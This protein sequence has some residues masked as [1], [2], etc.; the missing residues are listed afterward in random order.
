MNLWNFFKVHHSNKCTGMRKN[1]GYH[2]QH[3]MEVKLKA[4]DQC[5]LR[6]CFGSL[7]LPLRLALYG[8]I[9][10]NDIGQSFFVT[11]VDKHF[12]YS[13]QSCEK[14]PS[15]FENNDNLVI[16][17]TARAGC[18]ENLFEKIFFEFFSNQRSRTCWLLSICAQQ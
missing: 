18:Q 15:S 9:G 12:G 7:K 5:N 17:P 11:F 13:F 2:H 14:S 16:D 1:R 8:P 3:L 6:S 10:K 4:W